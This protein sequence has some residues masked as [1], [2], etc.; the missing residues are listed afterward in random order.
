VPFHST[1]VVTYQVASGQVASGTCWNEK[2]PEGVQ[3]VARRLA[4][5]SGSSRSNFTGP[6]LVGRMSPA[7]LPKIAVMRARLSVVAR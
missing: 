4:T 3:R 5:W 6:A 1:L 2:V 7:A